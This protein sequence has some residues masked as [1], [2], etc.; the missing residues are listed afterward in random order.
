MSAEIPFRVGF[1]Y[2]LHCFTEGR[3]LI[4]GGIEI[5]H[6]HGLKGHSDGDALLHAVADALLGAIGE[7]DIGYHFPDTAAECKGMDSA[8]IVELARQKVESAGYRIGNVDVTVITQA[9]K[10]NPHIERMKV[11]VSGLLGIT[12][13]QLGVKATTNEGCDAI[14][15]GEALACHA[16]CLLMR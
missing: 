16:V 2:D 5:A 7:R 1:G 12:E 15:R 13:G 4:L 10:I 3:P 11:R 8:K 6:T 9:P 14:G